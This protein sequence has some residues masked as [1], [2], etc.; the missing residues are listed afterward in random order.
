MSSIV[1]TQSLGPSLLIE[2]APFA[3]GFS[4]I[5]RGAEIVSSLEPVGADDSNVHGHGHPYR[6]APVRKQIQSLVPVL[7]RIS[8]YLQELPVAYQQMV[9]QEATFDRFCMQNGSSPRLHRILGRDSLALISAEEYI[10]G[11]PLRAVLDAHMLRNERLP[12]SHVLALGESLV[13]FWSGAAQDHIHAAVDLDEVLIDEQGH[14]RTRPTYRA[15]QS[16]QEVGAALLALVDIA[17][18]SAPEEIKGQGYE[19]RSS[20][21][22]LGLLLFELLA[23]THPYNQGEKK[24]FELFSRIVQQP[25]P[26]LRTRRPDVHPAVAAFVQRCLERDPQDRFA[27]WDELRSAYRGIQ[28]LFP[29]I[30][31]GALAQFALQWVPDHRERHVPPMMLAE[32]ITP[33]TQ[34]RIESIDLAHVASWKRQVRPFV[35]TAEVVVDEQMEFAGNDAR[36]ML[37]VSPSLLVDARPVTKAEIERYYFATGQ[38]FPP[39]LR[40]L[41]D[42]DDDTCVF[43]PIDIAR[44]YAAWAGKRVPTEQE[45]ELAIEKHGP[46]RLEVGRIWEWTDTPHE[47]GGWVVRG[48]RWRDQSTQPAR[49]ENRSFARKAAPDLGFRCAFTPVDEPGETILNTK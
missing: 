37:R 43:V 38:V 30:A 28:A 31:T 46:E 29:P 8:R 35:P 26:Y 2:A 3:Y 1:L 32:F 47:D 20:M 41:N 11:T 49:P 12:E 7:V 45:W 24:L 36:P 5:Y 14:L 16:R 33:F 34:E 18:L 25:A 21:F 17:A 39:N 10:V 19:A 44:A 40:G 48:G 15:E 22:Y 9:F 6:I 23:G 27:N 4:N 42:N 13:A